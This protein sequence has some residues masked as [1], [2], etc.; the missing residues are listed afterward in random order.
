M[1]YLELTQ[2]TPEWHAHR[3]T[4]FNASDAPA[5]LGCSTYKTRT[6]LLHEMATGITM[7]IDEATQRRFDEGHRAE[8]LARPLAEKIVGKKL[9]AVIGME[10]MLS[11]SFDGL[12][13]DDAI[14]FEHKTINHKIRYALGGNGDPDALPKMYSLLPEMYRAQMEQQMMIS[15]AGKCLFMA[16]KWDD[17]GG[18]V[19]EVHAWYLP[20]PDLRQRL[21]NGWKQFAIDLE[22]YKRK[23]TAGEIEQPKIADKADVIEALPAVFVQATGAVLATNLDVFKA[24][25]T[26][27][28]GNIKTELVT[29]HDF[30]DAEA[31][32]KF[33]KSAETNIEQVKSS[34]VAQMASVEEV[35]RT[36]D[37]I[38][39]KLRDK[40]LLL[41]K[42]VKS[43]KE[44]RKMALV[45]SA[46]DSYAQHVAGLQAEIAGIQLK[47]LL[48]NQNFVA[49]IKGLKSL[50]S[51]QDALDTAL[52]NSKIEADAIA[53][54][55]RQKVDLMRT[56]EEYRFLF[57]DLQQIIGKSPEDFRLLVE[58]RIMAHQEAETKKAE[59]Q[60]TT[61]DFQQI[62]ESAPDANPS[63]IKTESIS[64]EIRLV[65]EFLKLNEF[66]DANRIRSIL[67]EF[68]MFQENH[69]PT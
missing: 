48:P 63:A 49:V 34:V 32:V 26:A 65:A 64:G 51:M 3:A 2:G 59:E 5:M 7:G 24:S 57:S 12:T 10:G 9:Y 53:K 23:L 54:D 15:G 1:E 68:L 19:E 21:I 46:C 8:A 61:A 67:I 66:R 20:D 33:C 60:R 28:I 4:K 31:T 56:Y 22:E 58:S 47:L 38:G 37:D 36:L 69:K 16:S 29:D 62:Q 18:L 14:C 39:A 41:D 11:A 27:F 50:A 43:E 40:R 35:M 17:E 6:Q 44:A 55:V 42:L 30:A 45:T 25:A 13:A 52:A